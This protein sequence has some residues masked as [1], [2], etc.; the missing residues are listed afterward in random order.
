MRV[1]NIIEEGKLGG[2]QV[3]ISMI[4]ASLKGVVETTV[5]MP[6]KNSDAF[7]KRCI[8]YDVPYK[9]FLISR[10]TKE[11]RVAFQYIIFSFVEIVCLAFYFR[12]EKFDLIH[13]S[14][15]SWQYKGVI[16]GRLAGIKVVW[17][18]NDTAM[19]GFIRHLFSLISPL[20]DGFI[21]AS[22]RSRAYYLPLM[23][24][25]KP[26]FVIPAPVDTSRF[27]P[28][29]SYVGDEDLLDKLAGK[30]IIGT[31]ANINPIKGLET[32]IHAAAILNKQIDE[33]HFVVVGPVYKNQQGYYASLQRLCKELSV[34]NIEFV[35]SRSD[36]RP[37][38]QRFN[39]YVCSSRAESSPIAVWEAMAMGKPVVSTDVGDVSLYIHDDHN[40]FIIEVG[41]SQAL[42]DRLT[43]F[44]TNLEKCREF[45]Q[46][47]RDVAV[48][49]L[50]IA[51]CAERHVAAYQAM[52]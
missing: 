25:N 10:I 42:A 5:I 16:A 31:V 8:E 39:A 3:R 12:R 41:N 27:D 19:P 24:A 38:L 51:Q 2:P 52:R 32:F 28:K 20:A 13:A 45:G 37:L 7:R 6:S 49:K 11:W 18:L 47:A 14:G 4:A 23:K 36:V 1:A 26:E 29:G 22:E 34:D 30:F 48:H 43:Q 40:G 33:V 50:D 21:F 35:G 9:T 17:H 46:R 44:A 15:G